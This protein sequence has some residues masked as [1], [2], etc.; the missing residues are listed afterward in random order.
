MP[1][2]RSK[3]RRRHGPSDRIDL[4]G[5]GSSASQMGR[6][7]HSELSGKRGFHFAAAPAS[8]DPSLR[9]AVESNV[10]FIGDP[11][12]A[13]IPSPMNHKGTHAHGY[14]RTEGYGGYRFATSG[15]D[16]HTGRSDRLWRGGPTGVRA[17]SGKA[18]RP[19]SRRR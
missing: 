8:G 7:S 13:F 17:P 3:S 11:Y 19:W 4:L 6:T 12:P 14:A 2:S 9:R 16:G 10:L 5:I 18:F 15:Y 1:Y